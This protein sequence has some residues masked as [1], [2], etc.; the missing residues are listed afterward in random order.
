MKKLIGGLVAV[1]VLLLVG[2]AA[3]VPA[4]DASS[5]TCGPEPEIAPGLGL[6]EPEWV[7]D[8]GTGT[9]RLEGVSIN[10]KVANMMAV[11]CIGW[12]GR[13]V[14]EVNRGYE[15]LVRYPSCDYV[16]SLQFWG[17]LPDGVFTELGND[18]LKGWDPELTYFDAMAGFPASSW[19]DMVQLKV[20]EHD[21]GNTCSGQT[22]AVTGPVEVPNE[23]TWLERNA[24]P[25]DIP[26]YWGDGSEAPFRIV[27]WRPSD[28]CPAWVTD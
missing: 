6:E 22:W 16:G 26:T 8:D 24:Y 11:E 5:T 12:H 1:L 13:W 27:G 25:V 4:A 28:E 7:C 21:A 17:T 10:P 14:P 23:F 3:G 18:S 2:T 15:Y 19:L 9:W 20:C